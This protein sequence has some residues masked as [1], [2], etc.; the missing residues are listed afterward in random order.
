MRVCFERSM[1]TQNLPRYWKIQGTEVAS[2]FF[3]GRNKLVEGSLAPNPRQGGVVVAARVLDRAGGNVV[4]ARK[5]AQTHRER[6]NTLENVWIR[7]SRC[8]E[9]FARERSPHLV[10]YTLSTNLSP[11]NLASC[12]ARTKSDSV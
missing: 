9:P 4:A 11:S 12:S 10:I 2:Y 5:Q 1:K 8:N 7:T 6:D 3:H